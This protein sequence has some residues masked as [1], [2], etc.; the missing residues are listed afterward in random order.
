MGK[1]K[2]VKAEPIKR[3]TEYY[4]CVVCGASTVL[5]PYGILRDFRSSKRTCVCC[6]DCNQKFLKGEY[7]HEV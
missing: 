6:G 3:T 2:Q 1:S 4:T 7:D 5:Y